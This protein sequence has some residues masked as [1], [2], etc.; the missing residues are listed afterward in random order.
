MLLSIADED[1]CDEDGIELIR[2]ISDVF[3]MATVNFNTLILEY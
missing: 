2:V 3:F 1:E